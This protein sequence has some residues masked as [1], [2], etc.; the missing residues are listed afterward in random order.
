MVVS[1][2]QHSAKGIITEKWPSLCFSAHTLKWQKLQ[3]CFGSS[4]W[5]SAVMCTAAQSPTKAIRLWLNWERERVV[6]QV[7]V[8]SFFKPFLGARSPFLWGKWQNN[9]LPDF[10]SCAANPSEGK[11]WPCGENR[12]CPV[13]DQYSPNVWCLLC[14][15]QL[16]HTQ[17]HKYTR[18]HYSRM[19]GTIGDH[20]TEKLGRVSLWVKCWIRSL[21]VK[22]LFC[23]DQQTGTGNWQFSHYI[24]MC[25]YCTWKTH[26]RWTPSTLAVVS[27]L[28]FLSPW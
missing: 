6:R 13:H 5:D 24:S 15:L 9:C 11:V 10:S 23:H 16:L 21:I 20:V 3:A 17:T 28:P 7:Q 4:C 22:W 1:F 18:E 12:P 2:S 14:V 27:S 25:T 8:T 19:G 26:T